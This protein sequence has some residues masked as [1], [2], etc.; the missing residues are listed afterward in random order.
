MATEGCSAN[1]TVGCVWRVRI[2]GGMG[3]RGGTLRGTVKQHN[4]LGEEKGQHVEEPP[5]QFG[6][7]HRVV[8]VDGRAITCQSVRRFLLA[9]FAPRN[10][11]MSLL[12]D[13]R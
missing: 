10:R 5:R 7:H 2:C 12:C 3:Q 4:P 11:K 8:G 9:L 1:S 13:G 6:I